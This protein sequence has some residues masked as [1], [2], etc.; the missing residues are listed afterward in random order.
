[1]DL[2]V[3]PPFRDYPAS[4]PFIRELRPQ[5]GSVENLAAPVLRYLF[6]RNRPEL[7]L[8]RGI[9]ADS[10]SVNPLNSSVM[11]ANGH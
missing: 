3:S 2:E 8:I 11:Q 5:F 4:I 1:M 9:S 6:F 7:E 10:K